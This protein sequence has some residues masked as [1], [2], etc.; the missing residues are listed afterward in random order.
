M[1][2]KEHSR[3]LKNSK[4]FPGNQQ[5]MKHFNFLMLPDY[6]DAL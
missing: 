6:I 1:P 2:K 3:V 4:L 5:K